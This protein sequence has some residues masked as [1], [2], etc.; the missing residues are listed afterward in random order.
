MQSP[1]TLDV[2]VPCFN[3]RPGWGKLLTEGI[4]KLKQG[5]PANALQSVILVNDGS[6]NGISDSEFEQLISS[7]TEVK[8]IEY[9]KNKGKGYA[10]RS[11]VRLGDAD[12][13]IYTDVD[14]P[15]V[16][17]SM[18]G[19]FQILAENKADVVIA[20]R[21]ESYYN[22]LSGFRKILS[23]SLRSLN[24]LLFGLK[25][26]DTQ[27]GLKGFNSAGKEVFL[28]TNVNRYLFDLEFVQNLSKTELRIEAVDVHLK[29]EIVLPSLSPMILL[30]EIH[31]F[32]RLLI[33][34]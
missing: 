4:V 25:I 5:L 28:N 24:G 29:P 13:T 23:K 34:R 22:S 7:V 33:R 15:Y 3:P 12:F 14:F 1:K 21:G 27:G 9:S 17:E 18:V 10:V 11:G 8:I 6:T 31:N 30:K 2:V 16:E 32:I 26:K 20:S 19:F